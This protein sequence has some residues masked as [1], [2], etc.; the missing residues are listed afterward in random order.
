MVTLGA[1]ENG[2]HRNATDCK[3]GVAGYKKRELTFKMALE[4]NIIGRNASDLMKTVLMWRQIGRNYEACNLQL[5][6]GG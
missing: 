3:I 6:E 2:S 5:G 1:N 4:V